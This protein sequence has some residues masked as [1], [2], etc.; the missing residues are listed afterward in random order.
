M[1]ALSAAAPGAPCAMRTSW[2]GFSLCTPAVT[3]TSP[4]CRPAVTVT[5]SS[6]NC[7]TLTW[8][9]FTLLDFGST[10]Q[11]TA[12]DPSRAR[13]VRGSSTRLGS[14]VDPKRTLAVIPSC[15]LAGAVGT[16]TRTAYVLVT[17]SAP[18]AISRTRPGSPFDGSAQTDTATPWPTL[19]I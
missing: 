6:R 1:T 10:T 3:T 4:G 17:A 2:S 9:I 13:A 15:A 14:V 11:T 5:P 16:D 8:R 12:L 18:P 7:P 19:T